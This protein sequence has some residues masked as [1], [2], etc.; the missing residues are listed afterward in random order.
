M[1][2][3]IVTEQP[4]KPDKKIPKN[5]LPATILKATLDIWQ[6]TNRQNAVPIIGRS[7]L[8]LLRPGDYVLITHGWQGV[9]RGD[10]VLFHHQETLAVHRVI[11]IKPGPIF[12]TKGDNVTHDDPPLKASEILGRVVQIKRG[13]RLFSVDNRAWRLIGWLMV[14]M[15]LAWRL[16][17]GSCRSVKQRLLGPERNWLTAFLREGAYKAFAVLRGFL[18][19]IFSR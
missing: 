3:S 13:D 1:A 18:Q 5:R 6:Q 19:K 16:I 9:K 14:M 15:T 8:P 4:D 2:N 12:I 11:H 7:M 10:I 17:Y